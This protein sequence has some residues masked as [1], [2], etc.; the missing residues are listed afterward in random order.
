MIEVMKQDG[1]FALNEVP[2][3]RGSRWALPV[4]GLETAEPVLCIPLLRKVITGYLWSLFTE[5]CSYKLKENKNKVCHNKHPLFMHAF[6][7]MLILNIEL[8]PFFLLLRKCFL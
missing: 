1:Y 7:V 5:N 4:R 6:T 3:V 8:T 2:E